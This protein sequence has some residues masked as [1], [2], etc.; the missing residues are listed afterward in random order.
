MKIKLYLIT[1]L[2]VL[3]VGAIYALDYFYVDNPDKANSLFK[4]YLKGEELGYIEND[5]ELYSLINNEQKEIKDTYNVNNVYPPSDFDIVKVNTYNNNITDITEVYEKIENYDN[6]TI[7][8]Y[9]YIIKS[10]DEEKEDVIVNVLDEAIYDEAINTFITAFIETEVFLNVQN[11]TQEEIVD[12]GEYIK[13]MYFAENIAVVKENYISV[14]DKIY[15]DASELSQFLLFGADA[16]MNSY[17]VNVGDT[18]TSIANN[19]QL[20]PKEFLIANPELRN[21]ETL[22]AIG[23]TVNVTLLNPVLNFVYEVEKTEEVE[24]DFITTTVVDNTKSVGFSEP[25]VAGV[26]GLQKVTTNYSVV[27]GLQSKEVESS[28]PI[29][30]REVVNAVTTVG[31]SYVSSST[32]SDYVYTGLTFALPTLPGAIVTSPY[33]EWRDGYVHKGT[34]FS[35]IPGGSENSPIFAIADGTVVQAGWGSGGQ[36]NYVVIAHAGGYYSTYMHMYSGSIRVNAGD[37]VVAGQQI[38]GMG[39]TGWSFGTHLHIEFTYGRPYSGGNVIYY[40][41]YNI[42][43]G[44]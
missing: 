22:L 25:T 11:G 1:S 12:Y 5:D 23:S 37:T 36:G 9:T 32:L 17:T 41:A 24:V 27:N 39:N 35:G 21:P 43:Y 44:G 26:T 3:L 19:N 38:G 18:I 4:I 16:V 13:N 6:F 29:I 8:G 2:I 42:I 7:K 34:D 40:N 15:T 28:D 14:N 31:P 20:N 10:T 33:G 30:I